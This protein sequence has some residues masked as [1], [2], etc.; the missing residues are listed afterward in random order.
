MGNL[1]PGFCSETAP[2]NNSRERRRKLTLSLAFREAQSRITERVGV[3]GGG[4]ERSEWAGQC[5]RQYWF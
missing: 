2:S 3:G 1:K 5:S 4:R